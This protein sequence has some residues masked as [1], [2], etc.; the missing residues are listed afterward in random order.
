MGGGLI[1]I[2]HIIHLVRSAKMYGVRP[3]IRRPNSLLVRI[4]HITNLWRSSDIRP[5]DADAWINVAIDPYMN[6]SCTHKD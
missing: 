3:I 5:L 1:T 6:V 4:N 2:H